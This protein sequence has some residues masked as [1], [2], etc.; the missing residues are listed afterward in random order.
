V[1]AASGILPADVW[2]GR[3][4]VRAG[5][6]RSIQEG[7]HVHTTLQEIRSDGERALVLGIVTSDLENHR[8]V[9]LPMSWIVRVRDRR[10]VA[11]RSFT[12]RAEALARWDSAGERA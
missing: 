3:E 5:R 2:R 12:G 4:A 10:I 6:Q 11:I 9:T 1:S 8:Q 7:R